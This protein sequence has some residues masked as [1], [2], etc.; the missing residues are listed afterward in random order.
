MLSTHICDT[1][2]L[3]KIKGLRTPPIV[4]CF[5]CDQTFNTKCFTEL[6]LLGKSLISSESNLIFV[7][8][9]CHL[10]LSKHKASATRKSMN[11]NNNSTSSSKQNSSNA[12][13]NK[14]TSQ[15]HPVDAEMRKTADMNTALLH[16]ILSHV[17]ES[18][19]HGREQTE[20]S[21]TP[22]AE[23]LNSI[24]TNYEFMQKISTQ[25]TQL[26]TRLETLCTSNTKS[27]NNSDAF[28][29]CRRFEKLNWESIDVI[30]KKIDS[31]TVTDSSN[32][33]DSICSSLNDLSQKIS[34]MESKSNLGCETKSFDELSNMT[35][36]MRERFRNILS[37]D[38]GS[39]T[40]VND[41]ASVRDDNRHQHAPQ[42]E[43]DTIDLLATNTLTSSSNTSF[44]NQ[45]R[46]EFYVTKFST[47]TTTSMILD[48]MRNNGV[49]DTNLVKVKCLVPPTKDKSTL[50]F[51]SFK[52][53]TEIATVADTITKTGFWPNKCTIRTFKHKSIIDLGN[54]QKSPNFFHHPGINQKPK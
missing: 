20:P 42:P 24:E 8:G 3:D 52:I 25:V 54:G 13:T 48:Y 35:Q 47:N 29:I 41:E 40:F 21:T 15:P 37:D 22:T 53:D 49:H 45:N 36:Q 23:L 33:F 4:K 44:K 46:Y 5:G 18:N 14:T 30:N 11:I 16:K 9:K 26:S 32:Q 50:T 19:R 2:C 31:V 10:N 27:T 34:C 17:I 12:S 51:V 1:S 28:D 43:S 39:Y 6:P 38:G 7:C